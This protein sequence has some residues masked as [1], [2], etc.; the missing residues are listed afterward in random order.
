MRK[1]VCFCCL[2]VVGCTLYAQ[3]KVGLSLIGRFDFG[4]TNLVT[5]EAGIG[6]SLA[7][8]FLLQKRLQIRIE[9]SADHFIGSKLL[10]IDMAGNHYG[11]NPTMLSANGGPEY[12]FTKTLSLAAL[13][14]Y[15]SYSWFDAKVK[16]DVLKFVLTQRFG[17]KKGWMGA[18]SLSSV[19]KP[20]N[21]HFFGL[22]LGHRIF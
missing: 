19:L 1:S 7:V 3:R 6:G 16:D 21:V 11:G 4:A 12:F 10:F 13:Y 18:L 8:N 17:R 22:G 5:Q 9:G 14:G 2:L 15:V 20:Y